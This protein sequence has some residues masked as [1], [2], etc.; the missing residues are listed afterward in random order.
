MAASWRLEQ[1]GNANDS[2]HVRVYAWDGTAWMQRGMDIDG[3]AEYDESGG[4][5]SL[6]SDGS[7][8]AIGSN[9]K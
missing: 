4:S 5:V 3:E 7:A 6:S 9:W 1:P 2:G 8:V